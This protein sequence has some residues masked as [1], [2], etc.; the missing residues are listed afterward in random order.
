[1]CLNSI[2]FPHFRLHSEGLLYMQIYLTSLIVVCYLSSIENVFHNIHGMNN[3]YWTTVF[4]FF[5]IFLLLFG[6]CANYVSLFL[7]KA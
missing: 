5:P 4:N 3:F 6:L 1:M 7:Y 2:G